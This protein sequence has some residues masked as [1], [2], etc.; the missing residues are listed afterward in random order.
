MP[1]TPKTPNPLKRPNPPKTPKTLLLVRSLT[2]YR[3][4]A[5]MAI[6]VQLLIFSISHY[7]AI[8]RDD[9]GSLQSRIEHLRHRNN[10]IFCVRSLDVKNVSK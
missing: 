4:T 9:H 1:K 6:L 2:K 3:L 10:K 7:A 8:L 5:Y